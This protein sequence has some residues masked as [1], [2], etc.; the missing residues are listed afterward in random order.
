MLEN[1]TTLKNDL[2]ST[3]SE[4]IKIINEKTLEDGSLEFDIEMSC[5]IYNN[6][7]KQA[8]KLN[9]SINEYFNKSLSEYVEQIIN[10]HKHKE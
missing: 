8:K 2:Y 9:M 3:P 5:D 6:I 10:E 4:E 7:N 1:Q